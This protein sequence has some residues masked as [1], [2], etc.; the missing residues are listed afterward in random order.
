M[1]TPLTGNNWTVPLQRADR[2]LAA[3][4]AA[5][6]RGLA[7]GLARLLRGAAHPAA[8]AGGCSSRA[9]ATG[10]GAVI[11][12]ES[13]AARFFPGERTDRPAHPARRHDRRDRRRRRRRPPRVA[14]RHAARRPVLPVRARQRA[15]DDAVRPR[16]RRSAAGAARAADG[17]PPARAARGDLRDAHAGA[18]RR[19]VCGGD[20][21]RHPAP[22]RLRRHRAGA[23]RGR[24][25]RRDG[26]P[27]APPHA[28]ARDAAGAWREPGPPHAAGAASGRLPSPSPA[29]RWGL[30]PPRSPRGRCR[31]CCS[32]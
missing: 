17:G 18:H 12:S 25:L 13:V 15:V 30:A 3:R 6:G 31:R 20:A 21:A 7:D 24:H 1:V 9:D 19:R 4:T 16:H 8:I 14:H 5:A 11:V 23:G 22:R 32:A 27:G 2:A 28:R 26:L 29:S 10:P